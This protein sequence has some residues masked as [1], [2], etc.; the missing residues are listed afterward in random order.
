M[1]LITLLV[2]AILG[3]WALW[4][5]DPKFAQFDYRQS[6]QTSPTIIA[7]AGGATDE[8]RYSN[9]LTALDRSYALGI[10][11]FEVDLAMT[12][13]RKVVLLHDWDRAWRYWFGQS[14]PVTLAEFK[15]AKMRGGFKQATMDDLCRWIASKPDA[16]VFLHMRR[17]VAIEMAACNPRQT[18]A[19][20]ESQERADEAKRAGFALTAI[21]AEK[22]NLS[23][24]EISSLRTDFAVMWDE[25]YSLAQMAQVAKVR[26]VIVPTVN[27]PKEA[28]ELKK[29]GVA[30]IM[31]DVLT[32]RLSNP[33]DY[34]HF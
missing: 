4:R 32:D 31:T 1:R 15:A 7:H 11:W 29:S 24:K 30:G 9:S 25:E 23:A 33:A 27:D 3:L 5:P 2:A 12:T 6:V 17:E 8:G 14:K 13:D 20:V 28:A 21:N 10:R 19:F 18:I 16:R 34:P 22:G 26:R